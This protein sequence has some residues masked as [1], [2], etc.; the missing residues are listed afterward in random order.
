MPDKK[1]EAQ[2][3][4]RVPVAQKNALVRASQARGE[5]LTD[6][7]LKAVDSLARFGPTKPPVLYIA[8]LPDR[9][10]N[11]WHIYTTVRAD[12]QVRH[13]Q[14]FANSVNPDAGTDEWLAAFEHAAAEWLAANPAEPH[15]ATGRWPKGARD[16]LG[17]DALDEARRELGLA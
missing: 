16:Y 14:A 2:I 12:A 6:T 3:V 4:L 8:D 10:A 13:A 5:K 17:A 9:L 7:M 11:N 15:W 1:D